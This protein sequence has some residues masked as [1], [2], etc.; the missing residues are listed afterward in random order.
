MS[1]GKHRSY[2][3]SCLQHPDLATADQAKRWRKG[4]K[5]FCVT[6]FSH[7]AFFF[8]SIV[9]T[10]TFSFS[11]DVVDN[12]I[13]TIAASAIATTFDVIVINIFC[14]CVDNRSTRLT[15]GL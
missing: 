4:M 8:S 2:V 10:I 12:T 3:N 7:Q 15:S 11:V 13:A 5:E 1:R 6:F 9:I 14:G